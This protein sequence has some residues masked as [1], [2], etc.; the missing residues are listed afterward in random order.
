MPRR[1]RRG[2]NYFPDELVQ[3]E[4]PKLA[5]H[6]PKPDEH[7]LQW[8]YLEPASNAAVAETDTEKS[9]PKI[10]PPLAWPGTKPVA[11]I[12]SS[13]YTPEAQKERTKPLRPLSIKPRASMGP[14]FNEKRAAEKPNDSD[15]VK[16]SIDPLYAQISVSPFPQS[17]RWAYEQLKVA[18]DIQAAAIK[19]ENQKL[20]AADP[21]ATL[22]STITEIEQ[23]MANSRA[24]T[25]EFIKAFV[26]RESFEKLKSQHGM[27]AVNLQVS[28]TNII[29]MDCLTRLI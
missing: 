18:K 23:N 24:F 6:N 21:K 10:F 4:K 19:T 17:G 1:A 14:V 16:R 26:G 7:K 27:N 8:P 11:P 29:Q 5:A 15:V 22:L 2:T 3:P 25:A 9:G 13:I 12:T 28:C 20:A